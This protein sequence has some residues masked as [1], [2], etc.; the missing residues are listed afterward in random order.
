MQRKWQGRGRGIEFSSAKFERE[1]LQEIEISL[2]GDKKWIAYDSNELIKKMG[3]RKTRQT[4][5]RIMSRVCW[6]RKRIAQYESLLL[7]KAS[8]IS[9]PNPLELGELK[10]PPVTKLEFL[11]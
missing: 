10:K 1:E 2:R 5:T 4:P 9:L 7:D 11:Q 3:S 6:D 8:N